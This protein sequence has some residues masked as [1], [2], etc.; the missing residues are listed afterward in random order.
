MGVK[1]LATE[2][3]ERWY[4]NPLRS[5]ES[6]SNL[7]NTYFRP[8]RIS[9]SGVGVSTL[10]ILRERAWRNDLQVNKCVGGISLTTGPKLF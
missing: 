7:K 9:E 4:S 5:V 3:R 2:G 8:I 1:R 6:N 10:S